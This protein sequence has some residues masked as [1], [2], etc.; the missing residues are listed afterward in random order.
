[1]GHGIHSEAEG[2]ANHWSF[3]ITEFPRAR[4]IVWDRGVSGGRTRFTCQA[5]LVI[6]LRYV[7]SWAHPRVHDCQWRLGV[8]HCLPYATWSVRLPSSGLVSSRLVSSLRYACLIPPFLRWLAN[9]LTHYFLH[10]FSLLRDEQLCEINYSPAAFTRIHI[11]RF[12]ALPSPLLFLF[13]IE[14]RRWQT[15]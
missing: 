9:R 5:N 8:F 4:R 14:D 10:P 13:Q 12:A 11:A 7:T 2:N 3:E 15:R 6:T 1:M